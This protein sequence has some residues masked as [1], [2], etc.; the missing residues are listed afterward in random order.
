MQWGFLVIWGPDAMLLVGSCDSSQQ[1][2]LL[3]RM[4]GPSPQHLVLLECEV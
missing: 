4:M 1:A 3:L 2:A